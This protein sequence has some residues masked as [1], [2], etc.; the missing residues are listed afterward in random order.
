MS[1]VELGLAIAATVDICLRSASV[2]Q[3]YSKLD[4]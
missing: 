3:R 4:G 1:G 2:C